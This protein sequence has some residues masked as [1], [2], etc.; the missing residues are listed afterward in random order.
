MKKLI[1]I[2]FLFISLCSFCQSKLEFRDADLV[3]TQNK[4]DSICSSNGVVGM[5]LS[6]IV[7]GKIEWR[8]SFGVGNANDK[9]KVDSNSIFQCASISKPITA[10]GVLKL[11]EEGKVELDNDVNQYLKGWQLNDNKFTKDSTVTVRKL[12][13][14]TAGTNFSGS[15]GY[16]QNEHLPS[17]IAILNGKGNTPAVEVQSVPGTEWKYSG[18]GYLILQKLIEDVSGDSFENYMQRI[19]FEPLGMM[20]STFKTYKV[21]DSIPRIVYGHKKNGKVIKEGWRLHPESAPAG[22][23]STTGDIGLYIIEIQ[24]ILAGEKN[25]I[26]NKESIEEMLKPHMNNAGLGPY[27]RKEKNG[28]SYFG[29]T[30][31]NDGYRLIFDASNELQQGG[32]VLFFN[33][34]VDFYILNKVYTT[35]FELY[36][37]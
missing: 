22:L 5:D 26:L 23:W 32:F 16:K 20:N 24:S 14:H 29:H 34:E 4:I 13:T 28:M 11:V 3:K 1:S 31:A 18:G 6:V 7:K 33:S 35:I 19:L 15:D 10:I 8:H 36:S 21:K 25:G 17:L 12:L 27:T 30:G 2:F 37:W 9:Y